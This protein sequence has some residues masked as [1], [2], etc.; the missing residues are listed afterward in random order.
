MVGEFVDAFSAEVS[1]HMVKFAEVVEMFFDAHFGVEGIGFGEVSDGIADEGG[2]GE[3]VVAVEFGRAGGGGHEGG[4]DTDGGGFAGSVGA[5]EPD[6]AAGGDV[7]IDVIE[8]E[9]GA[10]PFGELLDFDH[11]CGPVVCAV[12]CAGCDV[13]LAGCV[14]LAAS[15]TP[16]AAWRVKVRR[17]SAAFQVGGINR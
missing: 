15:R 4:E 3:D 9:D 10:V 2:L 17:I 11:G 14:V 16:Q 1:G 6:D 12:R 7:E 5:E 13:R 8:S